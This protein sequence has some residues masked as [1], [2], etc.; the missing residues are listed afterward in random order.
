M[1]FCSDCPLPF[2]E[3]RRWADR[4]EHGIKL[5]DQRHGQDGENGGKNTDLAG[6]HGVAPEDLRHLCDSRGT[7]RG[8]SKERDEQERTAVGV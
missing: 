4:S 7:R 1:W 2:L 3:K 6:L 8:G 5:D